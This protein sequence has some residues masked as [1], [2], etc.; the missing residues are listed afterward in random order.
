MRRHLETAACILFAI[1]FCAGIVVL[2][3]PLIQFLGSIA[4]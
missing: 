2:F 4:R 1:A 3:F